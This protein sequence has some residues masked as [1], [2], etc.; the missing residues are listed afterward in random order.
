MAIEAF[1]CN[2][3]TSLSAE[4]TAEARIDDIPS[5]RDMRSITTSSR[6]ELR[7]S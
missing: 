5:V 6:P 3:T 7:R 4:K 1:L 2:A